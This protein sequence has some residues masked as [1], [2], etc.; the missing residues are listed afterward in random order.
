MKTMTVKVDSGG[1]DFFIEFPDELLEEMNL[2]I[3]DT[4][5]WESHDNYVTIRKKTNENSSIK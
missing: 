2:K 5:I 3:G 4:L 1:D